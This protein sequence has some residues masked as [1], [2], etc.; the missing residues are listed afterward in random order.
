MEEKHSPFYFDFDLLS[1]F[2][3]YLTLNLLVTYLLHDIFRSGYNL[4]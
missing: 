2:D 1:D 3:F 4:S